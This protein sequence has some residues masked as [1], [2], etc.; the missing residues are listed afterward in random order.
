MLTTSR[1]MPGSKSKLP[2]ILALVA[3]LLGLLFASNSTLDYAA[4]IFKMMGID[5]T[6]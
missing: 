3:A 2:A 6:Q 4:T 1:P 5:D